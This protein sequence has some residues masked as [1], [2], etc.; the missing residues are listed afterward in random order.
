MT[1][2]AILPPVSNMPE[3]E[4]L[5]SFFANDKKRC[6]DNPQCR[7]GRYKWCFGSEIESVKD[8]RLHALS[9]AQQT[10]L[11]YKAFTSKKQSKGN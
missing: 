2:N 3:I 11:R 10:A 9:I 8:W 6:K 4:E 5:E 7:C 1:R